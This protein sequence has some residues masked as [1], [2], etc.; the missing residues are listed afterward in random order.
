[1]HYTLS[2][3]RELHP[4]KI[5][6]RILCLEVISGSFIPTAIADG[7]RGWF[8]WQFVKGLTQKLPDKKHPHISAR[9]CNLLKISIV[10][11][12]RRLR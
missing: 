8:F 11:P 6:S 7:L 5:R 2:L 12:P 1:M 9:D 4:H 3:Q 10:I